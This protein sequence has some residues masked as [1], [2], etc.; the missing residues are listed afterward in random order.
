[1]EKNT[2][3]QN[4]DEFIFADVLGDTL[5]LK[6]IRG[7]TRLMVQVSEDEAISSLLFTRQQ[8]GKLITVL[9]G[10]YKEMQP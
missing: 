10:I 1:M 9:Q 4:E 5:L 2:A 3:V 8:V 7:E 6:T